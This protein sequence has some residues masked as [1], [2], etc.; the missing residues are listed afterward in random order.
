[1]KYLLLAMCTLVSVLIFYQLKYYSG[2]EF[3]MEPEANVQSSNI[4]D[5]DNPRPLKSIRAYSEIIERPLF[6]TDRKPPE[7][8]NQYVEASIDVAELQDL[9]IYGVVKSGE[10]SY[11]IIGNIDGDKEAKQI[12]VG[13][14]YKGWR[15]SEITSHSVRFASEEME[16][17]LFITPNESTKKSGIKS[18]VTKSRNIFGPTNNVNNAA[19][20]EPPK[21]SG[22]LIYNRSKKK[23]PV[24]IPSSSQL[25]NQ[26]PINKEELEKLSEEGAYEFNF[27]EESEEEF[28]EE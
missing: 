9:I 1:M 18:A 27:L 20:N 12:K 6:A 19:N 13:R 4:T 7:I 23:S 28:Y 26:K 2:A 3:D 15:V 21:T 14:N 8:K 25:G 10:L 22:G 5:G 24:K 17:E 11:A 16:Y